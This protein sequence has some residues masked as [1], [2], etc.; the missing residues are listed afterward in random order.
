MSQLWL[1][2]GLQRFGSLKPRKRG[3]ALK[4]A[5]EIRSTSGYLMADTLS[6]GDPSN[7]RRDFA[8][9]VNLNSNYQ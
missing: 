6:Q 2:R 9:N 7:N 4:I 5:E 8:L 1:P 3:A